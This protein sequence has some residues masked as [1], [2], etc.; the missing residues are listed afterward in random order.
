[1]SSSAVPT[2]Y[3]GADRGHY[4]AVPSQATAT[5]SVAKSGKRGVAYNDVKLVDILSSSPH[6]SWAYNW[7]SS[8][9]GLSKNLNFIPTL[10]GTAEEF[11]S[12]WKE[13]A[14]SAIDNGSKY[15]FSF[16]EPDNSAQANM[17]PGEAAAAYKQYMMPFAGKGV[18]LCAPSITNAG[19]NMGLNW[20]TS[21]I[22]ACDGC[23]IDCLNLHWYDSHDK[24]DYF[25]SHI[26]NATDIAGGKPVWVTEFGCTD[27]TPAD[28]SSFL[29]DVMPWMD[30]EDKVEGY[31]Y[32][33]AS[34]GLLVSGSGPS[35]FGNTYVSFSE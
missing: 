12:V 32:F 25:K 9:A 17:S 30:K 20:L 8:C 19:G 31:A 23:Q 33:M 11:V 34:E 24:T 21:F 5:S 7:A 2:D 10:W 13:N 16:N 3:H 6:V 26:Q 28:I 22:E 27:G 1:M 18:K 35:E 15:L 4:T 14:Q 29:Q